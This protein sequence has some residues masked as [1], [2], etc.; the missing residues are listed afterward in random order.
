MKLTELLKGIEGCEWVGDPG[1]EIEAIAYDSR[2]VRPGTLFVAFKGHTE[3]GHNYIQDAVR[4]GAA[5][6]LGERLPAGLGVPG[7]RVA[8]PK[9]VLSLIALRFYREPFRGLSLIGITGTNGKTTTTFLLES[10][11]RKAGANPG[12]IGTINYRFCGKSTPASVTTPESLD[13]IALGREMADASVTHLIMEVSSHALDQR[14]V[15]DC[16]FR[17]AV[18]TNLSRDHLDYHKDMEDYFQAKSVLFKD[19]LPPTGRP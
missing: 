3:D 9:R 4:R 13:L 8:D 19:L 2:K 1:R 5:A 15:C 17:T 10:I 14:R 16:P 6:V 18:F 12:V 7:I 11:L